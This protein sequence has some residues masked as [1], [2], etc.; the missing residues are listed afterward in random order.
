DAWFEHVVVQGAELA[1]NP[2]T[3]A[4]AVAMVGRNGS[5]DRIIDPVETSIG[6]IKEEMDVELER[7]RQ[8]QA[9]ASATALWVLI[10]GIV[11]ACLIAV[12]AGWTLTRGINGPVMLMIGY[13]RR[14]VGGDTAFEVPAVSRKDEFGEMGRSIIAFRDA[15]IEKVRLE[16]ETE[17]A[18]AAAERERAANEAQKA[19]EAEED[20]VAITALAEG[21]S[22]M[23]EGDL[24]Y[25]MTV[26]VAPK[27]AQ[28]KAD[29]NKAIAQ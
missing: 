27:A 7:V 17:E 13:M 5:A 3:H 2:A 24:T 23:A 18:R 14:L 28:L 26:E 29:F 21:L 8:A 15:A 20:R 6:K 11:M 10:L 25:R 12:G 1:R 4:S 19:R 16:R 9:D 22:A